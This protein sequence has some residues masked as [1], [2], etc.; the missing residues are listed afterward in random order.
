MG[1]QVNSQV[2]RAERLPPHRAG[3][4]DKARV[5]RQSLAHPSVH[6]CVHGAEERAPAPGPTAWA[7]VPSLPYP[8]L[9]KVHAFLD[10]RAPHVASCSPHRHNGANGAT[11]LSEREGFLRAVV[12]V[13]RVSARTGKALLSLPHFHSNSG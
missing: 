5:V 8:R 6:P 13:P 7:S 4:R 2:L 11:S 12:T 1:R 9:K 3:V 10:L